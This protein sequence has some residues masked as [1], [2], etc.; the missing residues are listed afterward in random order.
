MASYAFMLTP[1][2]APSGAWTETILYQFSPP[3]GTTRLHG[4][5]LLRPGGELFGTLVSQKTPSRTALFRLLPPA[6]PGGA[7]TARTLVAFHSL[8]LPNGDLTAGED[9]IV[10]GSTVQGSVFMLTQP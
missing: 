6:V 4:P 3:G 10:Y 8:V 9:G 5:L 1:P 7:W 2:T